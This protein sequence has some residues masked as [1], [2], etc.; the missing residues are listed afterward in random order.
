MQE[1]IEVLKKK[2]SNTLDVIKEKGSPYNPQGTVFSK[3][4]ASWYS[5]HVCRNKGKSCIRLLVHMRPSGR[6]SEQ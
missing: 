6:P 3:V 1:R 2:K 4:E 5:D